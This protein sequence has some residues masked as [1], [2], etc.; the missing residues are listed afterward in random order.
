VNRK[1]D[2]VDY[3]AERKVAAD[4]GPHPGFTEVNVSRRPPA[5]ELGV[6]RQEA[7]PDGRFPE[8]KPWV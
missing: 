8:V 5:A 6:R 3:L 7:I 4:R 2:I 1:R